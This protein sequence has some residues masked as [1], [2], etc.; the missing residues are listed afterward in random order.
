MKP[1]IDYLREIIREKDPIG[2]VLQELKL[3]YDSNFDI[4]GYKSFLK[5]QKVQEGENA[6]GGVGIWIKNKIPA[7]RVE[8]KTSLQAVAVSVMMHRRV[9]VCSIYLPPN[10]II[11]R[12]EIEGLIKELPKPFLLL[13]DANA[14]NKLWFDSR[15]DSRGK[16][17]QKI[18]EDMDIFLLDEATNTHFSRAHGTE[19]HID[20]SICSL[21]LLQDFSW[22]ADRYFRTSDHAPIYIECLTPYNSNNEKR[23]ITSKADWKKFQSE[24]ETEVKASD[25]SSSQEAVGFLND[26]ILQAAEQSIPSSQGEGGRKNPPWWNDECWRAIRK[27]KTAWTRYRRTVTLRNLLRFKQARAEAQRTIRRSKRES[28]Q[29]FIE[30][31]NSK[32]SVTEAWNK[33]NRLLNKHGTKIV[34]SLKIGGNKSSVIV[35]NIPM[36][37][38]INEVV[39]ECFAFGPVHHIEKSP[40]QDGTIT[41]K[42]IFETRSAM[43]KACLFLNGG[44]LEGNNLHAY[45]N[46]ENSPPGNDSNFLDDP[47]EIADALGLRFEF[48]SSYNSCE[49]SFAK[50]RAR[51]ETKL[52]FKTKKIFEYNSPITEQQLIQELDLI[53][54]SA[55]GPDV[56]HYSMLKNLGATGRKLLVEI[57][58]D[59]F[60]T[61]KLPDIWKLAH[62]IPILKEGKDPLKPDSYRPIA[63]TS[64]ICKLLERILNRRL[65]WFLDSKNLLDLVQTGFREGMST[66][67]NLV[68]LEDEIHKVFLRNEY[69]LTIFFDLAKAYDTCWRY[70]IMKE[71]HKAGMRGKLPILIEDFMSD[72][73]FQVKLCGK[74]SRQYDQD[75]GVP[76]GSVLSVTLFLIGINTVKNIL[77]EFI[78]VSIYVDDIRASIPVTYADWGRSTRRMQGFLNKLVKWSHETGFRFSEEKTVVMVFHRVPGLAENPTPKLYL[79]DKQTPLK[80]VLEKRFLGLLLDYKLMWIPQL[81]DLRIRGSRSNNIIKVIVKNNRKTDCKKLLNIY[82]TMTRSKLDYG[83]QVYGSASKTALKILDPVHHQ[84]LRLCTGAFRTSPVESIYVEAEEPSL[85]DRRS[86]LLLQYYTRAQK[87]PNSLVMQSLGNS[88]LDGRYRKS[89]R[90]PK[91]VSFKIRQLLKDLQIEMPSIMPLYKPKLIPWQVP[92]IACCMEIAGFAKDTTSVDFYQNYFC[93]HRHQSDIELYTDG[94]KG[95]YGVGAGAICVKNQQNIEYMEKLHDWSSVFNAELVAI[96]LGLESLKKYRS[97]TC[98]VYSDSLS[99]LQAIQSMK[100]SI[101]GIGM[102]YETLNVLEK[103]KVHV[104]FCWVPGH[105]GIRGNELADRVAKDACRGV[106]PDK[107]EVAGSD[108]KAVIKQKIGEVWENRWMNLTDNKKLREVQPTIKR[109][110]RPLLRRDAIKLTRLRIGHTRLTHSFLLTGD[111]MPECNY[112]EM[113]YTVKHILM[114]CDNLELDRMSYYDHSD[115]TLSTLLSSDEYIPRVLEF[116]KHIELYKEL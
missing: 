11:T 85:I 81:K 47:Q 3:P 73:K 16:I 50:S 52:Q 31:I 61:G 110:I 1:K 14:H 76:Q 70:L 102:I 80:I 77:N 105:S 111:D 5:T 60:D 71:L 54:E 7:H 21:D 32:V 53:D 36:N 65:R 68:S 37:A 72:R 9:T 59:I 27:R 33:I 39:K 90:K 74:L 114:E 64:C 103:R 44:F 115:V 89:R 4:K 107:V 25:F 116:L 23:W 104:N 63:L 109:K 45:H 15:D 66:I 87:L 97:K 51:R 29:N 75:M 35:E 38:D 88:G 86:M 49:P 112:C 46:R 96:Q 78:K 13:G 41:A 106:L 12:Q 26:L 58:N 108:F 30:S 95:E 100:M 92:R 10:K 28:W 19:S 99:S 22:T 17:I 101:K 56:I 55:P 91:S 98:T 82:R 113:P 69:L 83:C 84:A 62:V 18:V 43:E 40:Q 48:V 94:S 42:I 2:L 20:L 57:L 8:L 24:T 67:D 34:S 79:Y 93:S 6:Q